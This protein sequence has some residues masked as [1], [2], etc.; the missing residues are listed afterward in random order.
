M[1]CPSQMSHVA[2]C[3][4]QTKPSQVAV[5]AGASSPFPCPPGCAGVPSEKRAATQLLSPHTLVQHFSKS[6]QS[7]AQNVKE[8]GSYANHALLK[9]V[10]T[11]CTTDVGFYFEFNLITSSTLHS[12]SQVLCASTQRLALSLF[13]QNPSCSTLDPVTVAHNDNS[14]KSQAKSSSKYARIH[15][16]PCLFE[17]GVLFQLVCFIRASSKS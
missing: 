10:F 9:L 6:A 2:P 1:G 15:P 11:T 5:E 14:G 16:S 17:S 4:L 13:G 7:C 8:N 3:W 12:L